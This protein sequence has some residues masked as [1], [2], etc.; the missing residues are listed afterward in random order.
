[1][2]DQENGN[3][4][5]N[6]GEGV[7][8]LDVIANGQQMQEPDTKDPTTNF[9][10]SQLPASEYK[11]LT[12]NLEY[13]RLGLGAVLYETNTERKHVYFPTGGIISKLEML[14][15]GSSS[16]IALVGNEG[17]VGITVVLGGKHQ[18]HRAVVQ[19]AGAAYRVPASILFRE[20]RRGGVLMDQ[21]L[22][23]TQILYTQV[24]QTAVCN[25]HHN[26]QQQLSRWLLLSLDRVYSNEI[27]MT[28]EVIA[29]MLGVRREGIT[30]AAG[31]LQ[32]QHIIEYRRGNIT[33]I[34]RPR[35]EEMCC[36]C[37]QVLR[38]ETDRLASI[39]RSIGGRT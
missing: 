33:V 11:R 18:P 10:L 34:D 5:D 26:L 24:A 4:A 21:L 23:Y 20:S 31:E 38:R 1:M 7:K 13:T 15:D 6:K 8:A 36:E 16:E 2:R 35:L 9:L 17:M 37:Y 29:G 32:K 14:Q 28:Q 19:C 22:L 39:Q 27:A 12:R 3:N 30:R 25:R